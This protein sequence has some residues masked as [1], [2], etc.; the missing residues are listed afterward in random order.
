LM[1]RYK[2]LEYFAPEL[3]AAACFVTLTSKYAVSAAAVAAGWHRVGQYLRRHGHSCWVVTSAVQEKRLKKY[4]D[5]V[6]HYHVV[7]LGC[8]WIPADEVRAAWGLGGTKHK[9]SM[10]VLHTLHYINYLGHNY[11]RLSWSYATLQ[12][13]PGGAK[14]HDTCVRYFKPCEGFP[15]GV[16]N[17]G[18]GDVR[19]VRE[20]YS[21]VPALGRIVPSVAT[22]NHTMLW[23]AYRMAIDWESVRERMRKGVRAEND[24]VESM[25]R[26][27]DVRAFPTVP[28]RERPILYTRGS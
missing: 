4:G 21:Y 20:G 6:E 2:E 7:I 17:I 3:T 28:L 1:K 14:P 11:G 5:A 23:T 9:S 13:I 18:W 24:F 10:S 26:G 25:R 27:Y 8:T 15:G 12:R 16:I 22:T 19:Q